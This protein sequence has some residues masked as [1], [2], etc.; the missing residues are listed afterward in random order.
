MANAMRGLATGNRE[1]KPAERN[2]T[3]HTPEIILNVCRAVWDGEIEL[4]PCASRE[5][6][7]FAKRSFY[8]TGWLDD[9]LEAIWPPKSF[10]NPPYKEL[11]LWLGHA[12]DQFEWVGLY[13]VRSNRAWWCDFHRFYVTRVAW[14]KPLVFEGFDGGTFPAPLVLTYRGGRSARFER[15]VH[16]AGI[17]HWIGAGI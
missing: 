4:D 1:G 9:G 11:G 14:L 8:G 3:V 16:D 17:S 12:R 15:A 2:Q 13:P 10:F 6:A 7:P 5:R